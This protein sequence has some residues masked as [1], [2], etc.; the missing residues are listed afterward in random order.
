MET[1]ADVDEEVGEL[2]LMEEEVSEPAASLASFAG[3]AV[4][5]CAVL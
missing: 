5:C 4:L 2:F 3:M 1:V